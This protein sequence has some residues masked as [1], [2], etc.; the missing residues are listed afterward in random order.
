VLSRWEKP[1]LTLFSDSDPVT[2]GLERAFQEFV[3]GAQ[4]QPHRIIAGAGHFLQEDAGE[5]IARLVSEFIAAEAC[6][7]R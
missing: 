3:P 6:A 2:G 1:F 7:T 5:E 4:G